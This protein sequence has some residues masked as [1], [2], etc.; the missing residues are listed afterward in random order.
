MIRLLAS[1]NETMATTPIRD[2][3]D[4][5]DALEFAASVLRALPRIEIGDDKGMHATN[6]SSTRKADDKS[7][8]ERLSELAVRLPGL[9]RAIA[10]TEL[11]ALTVKA[12]RQ[13]APMLDVRIPS[14]A[15]KSEYIRILLTQ[16]FDAPAGQELIRSFHRRNAGMPS[17]TVGSKSSPVNAVP[18]G[19]NR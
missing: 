9:D 11:G 6:G 13:L 14:K 15:T 16:L 7:L 4:L 2:S 5:A 8:D 1:R 12:I 19:K 18:T 3:H 10:E 17:G